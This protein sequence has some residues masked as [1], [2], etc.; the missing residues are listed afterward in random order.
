MW[1]DAAFQLRECRVGPIVDS[2]DHPRQSGIYQPAI[3][4]L[5]HHDCAAKTASLHDLW[6]RHGYWIQGRPLHRLNLSCSTP[7][8]VR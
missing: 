5:H 1:L 3:L 4:H 7:K 2:V 6:Y 8:D